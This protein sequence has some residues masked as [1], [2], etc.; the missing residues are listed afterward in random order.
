MFQSL[1][2]SKANGLD[3]TAVYKIVLYVSLF[4]GF[5][6][7]C[8]NTIVILAILFVIWVARYRYR[9]RMVLCMHPLRPE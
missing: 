5:T 3:T 7:H 8:N 2:I 6:A 1:D 9:H 4:G